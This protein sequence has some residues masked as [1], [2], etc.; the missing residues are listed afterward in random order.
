VKTQIPH[1][2]L[3]HVWIN[4]GNAENNDMPDELRRIQGYLLTIARPDGMTD[5]AFRAFVLYG[6]EFLVNKRLFFRR[7]KLNMP[8]TRVIWHRNERNN[9]IQQLHDES[10]HRGKKGTY[11]KIALRY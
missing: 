4:N 11:Q 3:I 5:K 7:T 6:T 8:P 10:G 2:D 9:I 1:T